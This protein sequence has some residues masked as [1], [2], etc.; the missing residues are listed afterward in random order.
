M[1]AM[2]KPAAEQPAKNAPEW[3]DVIR[4]SIWLVQDGETWQSL[5][6]EFDIAGQGASRGLALK[7][8]QELV[9]EYLESCIEDGMS[10]EETLRPIPRR[11]RLR[12]QAGRLMTPIRRLRHKW[13]TRDGLIFPIQAD[14]HVH[15]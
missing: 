1:P 9:I 13:V 10:F 15:C 6:A 4:V 5:A 11:E 3:P 12:L 8:L 14:G 2:T 7:N